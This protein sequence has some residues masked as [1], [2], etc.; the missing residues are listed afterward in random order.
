MPGPKKRR[1]A[2]PIAPELKLAFSFIPQSDGEL[3]SQLVP[4][5][6]AIIF[7]K[8]RDDL[9]IAVGDE[10]V[11]ALLQFLPALNVIEQLAIKN[12][13]N[14][15]VFVSDRLLAVSQADNA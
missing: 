4:H 11:P 14:T 9:G 10:A 7:P 13:R 12:D 8:M 5:P 6:L 1:D 15:A 2:K 3:A